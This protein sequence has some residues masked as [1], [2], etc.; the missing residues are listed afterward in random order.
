[1]E[2]NPLLAAQ[3][4]RVLGSSSKT[5]GSSELEI[6]MKRNEYD[7]RE[8]IRESGTDEACPDGRRGEERS[9]GEADDCSDQDPVGGGGG[10][11]PGVLERKEG[12]DWGRE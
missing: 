7:M 5:S 10:G 6:S 4:R 11:G 2:P 9:E 1:M 3:V 8:A 12:A